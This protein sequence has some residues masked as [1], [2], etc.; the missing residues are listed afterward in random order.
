MDFYPTDQVEEGKEE[1]L[2][3]RP[4]QAYPSC[5][6]AAIVNTFE[7][8]CAVVAAA[9]A[10]TFLLTVAWHHV[11]SFVKVDARAEKSHY[12]LQMVDR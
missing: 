4:F 10:A 5:H 3:H 8:S 6:L 1:H 7:E 12:F 9:A 11:D 2:V